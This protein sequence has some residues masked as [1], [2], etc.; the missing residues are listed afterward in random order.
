MSVLTTGP[1]A[2]PA[3]E[4]P[5]DAGER[6]R[7]TTVTGLAALSLERDGVGGVRARGDR[8]RPGRGGRPRPGLHAAGDAGHR[9][10][11]GGAGGIVPAGD[12]GLP[13]RRRLL[14]GRED[15]PG[16]A[17]ESG[18]RG[19]AGPGL[20][21]E[22][23]RGG[24]G[25][26]GGPDLR[27][28]GSPQRPAVAL[29]GGTRPDH[30][31]QPAW[32]PGVRQGV[33]RADDRL[34]R[35]DPRPHS[36]RSVPLRTREHGDSRR[37][38]LGRRGRRHHRGG[39]APAESLRLR[40][41]RSDGG[42]GHRQRRPLLPGPARQAGPA[43]GGR[44]RGRPRRDAHRSVGADRPFPPPAGRGRHGPR[45]ARGRLAR[46][47]LGVLR[48]PVRDHD[49]AGPIGEHLLRRPAGAAQAA[50]PRQL[51]AARVRLEGGPAGPPARW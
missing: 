27:L 41:C 49:F 36:C 34:R 40:L 30:R 21:P 29:P 11:A 32:D 25:R 45:P 14:R 48:H 19:L 20:R 7:L 23:R 4:E 31:G 37:A 28:P 42:R 18:G 39:T 38:R 3:G 35:L 10:P 17:H 5:P 50:G 43:R 47:Q 26:S 12:R 9:R 13:G 2:V 6:H 8:P 46:P 16:C 22:R 24:H 33:H 15:P 51:R 1:S 44:P